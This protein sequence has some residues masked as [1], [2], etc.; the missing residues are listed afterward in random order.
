MERKVI[1]I[2]QDFSNQEDSYVEKCSEI[3]EFWPRKCMT[4][5]VHTFN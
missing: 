1:S 4:G 2:A 5:Y 3:Y